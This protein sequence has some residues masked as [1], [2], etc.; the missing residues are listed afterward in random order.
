MKNRD[1]SVGTQNRETISQR[2]SSGCFTLP[3]SD[4]DPISHAYF[5]ED[6]N[7]CQ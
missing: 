7:G 4:K 6:F 5:Q 3:D 2:Q 1:L